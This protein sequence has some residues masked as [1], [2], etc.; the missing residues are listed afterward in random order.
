MKGRQRL[1]VDFCR[2]LSLTPFFKMDNMNYNILTLILI[3]FAISGCAKT[4]QVNL[5]VQNRV[6]ISPEN[7][8]LRLSS[9]FR[10]YQII[11]LQGNPIDAV[12]DVAVV[13]SLLVVRGKSGNSSVH[14]YNMNGEYKAAMI[15]DGRGAHE[16]FIIQSFKIID[17]AT[18]EILGNFAQKLFTYSLTENKIIRE[19]NLPGELL[20]AEDFIKMDSSRYVFFK[21]RQRFKGKEYKVNV[22]NLN[23]NKM[24][25]QYI[26]I[27][28]NDEYI[29]FTQI[30]HLHAHDGKLLF[31]D[32]FSPGIY[33][34]HPD[35]LSLYIAF[36]E[37][38]FAFPQA[39]LEKKYRSFDQF[40]KVCENCSYIWGHIDMSES[41][42]YIFSMYRYKNAF[43]L[44][45][46]DKQMMTS[47]SYTHIYD[48]LITNE[49]FEVEDVLCNV[50]GSQNAQ[51]FYMEP[52][53]FKEIIE[54]K[55]NNGTFEVYKKCYPEACALA[56]NLSDDDNSLVIL[57][58]E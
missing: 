48:D 44:N 18:V 37:G 11:P 45:V 23:T 2:N 6:E 29:A 25:H 22:L 21:P 49:T 28:P 36:E 35:S 53:Q 33:Q 13:D 5:A 10:N 26:P 52:F 30:R 57:F 40:A 55:K 56:E 41:L 42:R 32:V 1:C 54:K 9:L 16:A 20:G 12:I 47:R 4:E 8:T 7:G 58:Y 15:P 46:I 31:Y 43:Y 14:L 34:I 17:S 51:I 39:L 50:A 38:K 27:T 19:R 24:E 3:V